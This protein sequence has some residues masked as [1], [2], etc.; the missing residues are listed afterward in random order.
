MHSKH[1]EEER[2]K[3]KSRDVKKARSFDGG[4]SKNRLQI[5]E[6]PRFKKWIFNQVLSKFPK[7]GMIG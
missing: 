1:V 4:S 5:L 7:I 3:R 2:A 6:N